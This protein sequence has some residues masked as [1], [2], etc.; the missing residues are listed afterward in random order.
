MC[1]KKESFKCMKVLFTL[2][3]CLAIQLN[4]LAQK[5]KA[6]VDIKFDSNYLQIANSVGDGW[7]PTWAKDG[8]LLYRQ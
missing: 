5:P 6:I 3:F 7:A 2:L 8:D 1:F 4:M